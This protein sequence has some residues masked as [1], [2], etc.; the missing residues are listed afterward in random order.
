[1]A[2]AEE[3]IE[4][5]NEHEEAEELEKQEELGEDEVCRQLYRAIDS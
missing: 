2:Q 1:M 4:D 3:I 5:K